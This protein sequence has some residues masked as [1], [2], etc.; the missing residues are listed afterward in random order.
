MRH[1]DANK[2]T[3]TPCHLRHS[4]NFGKIDSFSKTVSNIFILRNSIVGWGRVLLKRDM[5]SCIKPTDLTDVL[6]VGGSR[7]H[8]SESWYY[9]GPF[10]A[11][12]VE[13]FAKIVFG[14]KPLTFFVNFHLRCLTG[15]I[16]RFQ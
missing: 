3:P 11:S 7:I 10:Q 16:T 2:M 6:I 15:S 1:N 12:K 5:I 9:L 8:Q 14:Y 13:P 4:Q